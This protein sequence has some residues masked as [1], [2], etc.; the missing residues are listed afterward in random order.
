MFDATCMQGNRG[1]SW[2]LMVGNQIAN[3]T[4][5]PSFGHILCLK[6]ENESC[7]PILDIYVPKAFQW[8]KE[9]L[10][11]LGFDPCN[12]SLKI[13]ESIGTPTPKV[14]APLGVWGFIPS[15]SFALPIAWDVIPGP[16]SWAALL[17]ALVLVASPRLGLQQLFFYIVSLE[18]TTSSTTITLL[19]LRV[20]RFII[21]LPLMEPLYLLYSKCVIS[22]HLILFWLVHC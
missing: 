5:G 3:L 21:G 19:R 8:C 14:G 7:K 18:S 12:C 1:D 22:F 2:L 4:H 13:W 17:Q 9:L 10:N 16:P 6:C 11:P 20:S 15:H